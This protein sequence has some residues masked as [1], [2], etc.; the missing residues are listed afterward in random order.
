MN[1]SKFLNELYKLSGF[2]P[3]I[4]KYNEGKLDEVYLTT[5]SN[6]EQNERIRKSD[7]NL[8]TINTQTSF[9]PYLLLDFSAVNYVDSAAVKSILQV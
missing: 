8:S 9:I 6:G 4:Q 1:T 7:T 2:G 5:I 3:N